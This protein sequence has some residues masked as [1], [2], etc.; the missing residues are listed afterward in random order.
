LDFPTIGSCH[1]MVADIVL[2]AASQNP[3]LDH[4]VIAFFKAWAARTK[5]SIKSDGARS[6][7]FIGW[8]AF[9]R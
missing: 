5:I 1:D 6:E 9:E 8:S 4:L 7:L 3:F 2:V